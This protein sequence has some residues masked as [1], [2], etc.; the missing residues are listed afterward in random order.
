MEHHIIKFTTDR[1]INF[2]AMQVKNVIVPSQEE[3]AEPTNF[4]S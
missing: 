3:V 1:S 2:I 4:S